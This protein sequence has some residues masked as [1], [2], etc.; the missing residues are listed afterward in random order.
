M[1]PCN[2]NSA[3][4]LDSYKTTVEL[5]LNGFSS[6]CDSES[7][8]EFN[9]HGFNRIIFNIKICFIDDDKSKFEFLKNTNG[10]DSKTEPS[11][12]KS[13]KN[14]DDENSIKTNF[15]GNFGTK[16]QLKVWIRRSHEAIHTDQK[17]HVFCGSD[18]ELLNRHHYGLYFYRNNIKF[19]LRRE[20]HIINAQENNNDEFY[21]SL[22][23]WSLDSLEGDS[24][25]HFYEI[26]YDYPNAAL[27]I[28]G[29]H[30]EENQ[31][32]SDIIDAHELDDISATG[33][34]VSYVGACYNG[35]SHA[36][37]NHFHGDIAGLILN[38]AEKSKNCA[39]SCNEYLDLN[40]IGN[41]NYLSSVK[42]N[43]NDLIR[44]QTKTY[45]DLV[46]LLKK[47]NYV[48]K[49]L[50]PSKLLAKSQIGKRYLKL[51]TE[52]ICFKNPEN[53]TDDRKVSTVFHDFQIDLNVK[54]P[55]QE[56]NVQI[57]G[58]RQYVVS[59]NVL[60]N[61]GINLFKE[62]SISKT[63][64]NEVNA[65][66]SVESQENYVDSSS[67]TEDGD[68]IY[69][70]SCSI[71]LLPSNNNEKFAIGAFNDDEIFSVTDEFK[72]SRSG[73]LVKVEG[74]NSIKIYESYLKN[75]IYTVVVDDKQPGN[76]KL[77]YLSCLRNEPA[78]ETNTILIQV[79]KSYSKKL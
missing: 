16:F 56:I 60:L 8:G 7:C 13:F 55:K 64:I 27:Y 18:S 53:S 21:P 77:F 57:D 59:K 39:K 49:D 78:I 4:T 67:S 51:K 30:Y 29:L 2:E 35:R 33:L 32:N 15:D 44:I 1:E 48:N 62:I 76:N 73:D 3:C 46:T 9:Y 11:I 45:F 43:Q 24:K 34:S 41:E 25:W 31:T 69:F 40:M 68:D 19:L 12:Y 37:S 10:D 42:S 36:F 38:K 50:D 75:L 20:K 28:D 54:K 74:L 58:S 26:K 79:R 66:S 14:S 72:L 47:I 61:K 22:W 65:V 70:S 17:E 52:M 23:Q 6:G 71:K 5:D 63:A